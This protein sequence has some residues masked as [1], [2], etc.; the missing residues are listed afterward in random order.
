MISLSMALRLAVPQTE[1]ANP[2]LTHGAQ[3][4]T[5]ELLMSVLFDQAALVVPFEKL[6]MTDVESVAK[7]PAWGR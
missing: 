3:F 1:Q 7:M 2:A 4:L 6:R 5:L